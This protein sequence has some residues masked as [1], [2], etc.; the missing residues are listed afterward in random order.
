MDGKYISIKLCKTGMKD[1]IITCVYFPCISTLKDYTINTGPIIGH[2]ENTLT[3]YSDARHIIAGDFNFDCTSSNVGFDLLKKILSDYNLVFCDSKVNSPRKYTYS[4]ETLNQ[5]SWLDHIFM[6]EEL[7]NTVIHCD[8]IDMGEN[9]S[10][11]LPMCCTITINNLDSPSVQ[12][13]SK[14]QYKQR[15]DKAGLIAYYC[16]TGALLQSIVAPVAI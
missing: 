15:W 7:H 8:I 12:N 3:S 10:D 13:L 9:L 11:H 2:I 6:S 4:H 1:V 5:N 16:Q 14:R